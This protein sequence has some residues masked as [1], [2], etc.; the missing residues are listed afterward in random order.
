[1]VSIRG[2]WLS[3]RE[4]AYR[5]PPPTRPPVVIFLPDVFSR[6][7]EPQVEQAALEVLGAC[8]YDV[9]VLPGV[10]AGASFYSKGFLE[11]A[12]RHAWKTLEALDQLDP[13]GE[14]VIVG[15]EPPEIYLLKNEYVDLVPHQADEIQRRAG[16][17]WLL[18]EFLLRSK[19]FESLRVGKRGRGTSLE[20]NKQ[21]I[22]FHPHC[23]QRAEGPAS[24]GLPS[25]AAASVALLRACGYQTELTDAGCCGMAGT[26]GYESEHYDLS[27]KIAGLKLVPRIRE[28][29]NG[30]FVS[31][32]GAACRMQIRHG[33]G[34]D[35]KHPI[36]WVRDAI[37]NN[38]VTY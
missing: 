27:M 31:S 30:E 26:F 3:S 10:G 14:A 24:D 38:V 35:A 12:R 8:G 32:S 11:A 22:I 23:H 2:R 29:A 6:Y 13:E 20:G 36:E 17:V 9:Q 21:K 28:L 1:V 7:V 25:G 37:L 19:E 16:N 15:V 5:N 33:V 34:M 18:D 4:A